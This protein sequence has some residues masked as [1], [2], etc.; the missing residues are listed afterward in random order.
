MS[1]GKELSLYQRIQCWNCP[2]LKAFAND[3]TDVAQNLKIEYIVE[4][5]G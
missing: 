3:K 1:S 4:K 2:K 5:V